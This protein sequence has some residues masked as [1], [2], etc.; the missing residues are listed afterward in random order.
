MFIGSGDSLHLCWRWNPFGLWNLCSLSPLVM[1]CSCHQS[2]RICGLVLTQFFIQGL[3]V[4]SELHVDGWGKP[5]SRTLL[6][7]MFCKKQWT[8]CNL[9]WDISALGIE[10]SWCGVV[11]WSRLFLRQCSSPHNCYGYIVG[12]NKLPF[13]FVGEYGP[14]LFLLGVGALGLGE[15]RPRT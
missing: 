5:V 1:V 11:G 12:W 10:V 3:R 9:E 14:S 15:L 13:L 2:Y 6:L 7:F 4:H 8:F